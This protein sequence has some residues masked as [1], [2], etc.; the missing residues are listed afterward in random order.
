MDKQKINNKI[1]DLEDKKKDIENKISSLK[2]EL[3][4][5]VDNTQWIS[6]DKD[7]EVT[8]EV[9]HK[10]KSYNEIMQL[11]KPNEELLTLKQIAIILENPELTEELKMD[12]SYS[13]NNDFFFVYKVDSPVSIKSYQHYPGNIQV[14]LCPISFLAQF[15]FNPLAF[16]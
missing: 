9:L 1:K 10:G 7:F 15:I 13:T 11:K 14:L 8:K 6:L 12:A 4:N 16:K 3:N 5:E 2:L